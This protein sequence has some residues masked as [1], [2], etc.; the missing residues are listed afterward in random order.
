MQ[1]PIYNEMYVVR[2]LLRAVAALQYPRHLLEVQILNDSTDETSTLIEESLP[3]L[4]QQGLNVH[5]LRRTERRGFKA[6]ALAY[7]LQ[8]AQGDFIAIFDADFVPAPDFL[9]KALPYFAD[10]QV[11]VVQARWGHLNRDYSLLTE[12][13]AMALDAHFTIEQAGRNAGGLFINF[14]GTAGL[15]RKTTITDAGGWQADTLTEDLDLSY[16]AQLKGWKFI[17]LED[18]IVP[19]ELPVT[20]DAIRSQQFRWN[21][22]AAECARKHVRA[23]LLQPMPWRIRLHALFHLL[24]SSAFVAVLTLAVFSL[25]LMMIKPLYPDHVIWSVLSVVSLV[26]CLN[27]AVFFYHSKRAQN[28]E[29]FSISRFLKKYILLLCVYL[30]LSLHNALAVVEGFLGRH[31]VFERTPKFNIISRNDDWRLNRYL[32]PR[33]SLKIIVE[34][35][36]GVVYAAAIVVS[37]LSE[38]WMMVPFYILLSVGFLFV[39]ATSIAHARRP[40]AIRMA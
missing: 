23:I 35:L 8:H 7:G 37:A 12:L 5:H 25:P 6:G 27:F 29:S 40:L 15:W 13:Q 22:G 33:I 16:R 21:K 17:Y 1:L 4:R 39:F 30:G 2:R 31:S 10:P 18:L 32:N 14:N 20:M 36:L 38:Q 34:G 9:L 3:E 19:A 24:N 28:L 26:S 11:G